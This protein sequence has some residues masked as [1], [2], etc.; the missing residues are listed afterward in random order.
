V[1]Q[2]PIWEPIVKFL[3]LPMIIQYHEIEKVGTK[4]LT[5]GLIHGHE[6][7]MGKK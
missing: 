5:I 6:L 2:K 3:N 7:E 4:E 1:G